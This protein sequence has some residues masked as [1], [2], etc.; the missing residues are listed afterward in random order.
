LPQFFADLFWFLSGD[1]RKG[2]DNYGK[3]ALK[4]LPGLIDIYLIRG[5]NQFRKEP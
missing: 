2:K 4:L 5:K 1:L 3:I